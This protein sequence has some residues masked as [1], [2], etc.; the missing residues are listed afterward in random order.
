M[1][2]SNSPRFIKLS[3]DDLDI[4]FSILQEDRIAEWDTL[5]L[6]GPAHRTLMA[7]ASMSRSWRVLAQRHLFRDLVLTYGVVIAENCNG[8]RHTACSGYGCSCHLNERTGARRGLSAFH[9]FLVESPHIRRYARSLRIRASPRV[10]ER[11]EMDAALLSQVLAE[12]PGLNDLYLEETSLLLSRSVRAQTSPPTGILALERLT[13]TFQHA[14]SFYQDSVPRI[15]AQCHRVQHIRLL[16]MVGWNGSP[17]PG[18]TSMGPPEP[19]LEVESVDI[20]ISKPPGGKVF[21]YLAV[22]TQRLRS[23]QVNKIAHP[24]VMDDLQALLDATHAKLERFVYG[25]MTADQSW[26]KGP[27]LSRCTNLVSV[28]IILDLGCIT[29]GQEL[30]H[31]INPML[32]SLQKSPRDKLRR[33]TLRTASSTRYCGHCTSIA[34]SN[35]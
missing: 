3:E 12:L 33:I 27:D 13:L 16:G 8:M 29:T 22:A 15:L 11:K 14:R 31:V 35:R 17:T 9:R 34:A 24:E 18:R 6:F 26:D 28:E 23:I 19:H 21:K 10:H 4:V 5:R 30:Q 2:L 20:E 32:S 7:C 25:D 1:L